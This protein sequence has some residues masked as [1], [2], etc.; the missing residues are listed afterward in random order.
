MFETADG[1][2]LAWRDFGGSEGAPVVA[3]HGSPGSHSDFAPV[4]DVAAAEG[5][6][7]IAVDRAGY[8]HSTFDPNR[9]Y[10]RSAADIGELADHL[11]IERF[12]VLGWSSGGP[13]A[14]SCAQYLGNRVVACAIVSGPAPPE[15]NIAQVSMSPGIRI[16]Q[17]LALLAPHLMGVVFGLGMRWG[18][19]TPDKAF[20]WM[21]QNLPAC[22]AAIIEQPDVRASVMNTLRR[23][24]SPTAGRAAAQ[25]LFL[26]SRAWGFALGD[27][28]VPVHVWHGDADRNVAVENGRYQA[29]TIPGAVLHE[30]RAEGHWLLHNHFNEIL[31]P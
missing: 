7:L 1:R 26:E 5:V 28:Q 8:G 24:L 4:G 31:N 2:D 22:D 25:D 10:R 11:N 19:R 18:Q 13:N 6:R 9:T 3:L 14:A 15:A 30:V 17:R 12:G 27:I 21:L 29:R 23:P 20:E 16:W